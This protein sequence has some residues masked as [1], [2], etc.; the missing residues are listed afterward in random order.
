[1]YP[2][3]CF[4]SIYKYSKVISM[5]VNGHW[6]ILLMHSTKVISSSRTITLGES[7]V[8]ARG[9]PWGIPAG[10]CGS[11][12]TAIAGVFA[13]FTNKMGK[14]TEKLEDV[15]KAKSRGVSCQH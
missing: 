14:I 5:R 8:E 13:N 7:L 4:G 11:V 2:W 3:L 9:I 12:A 6:P 1:M 10:S 15:D